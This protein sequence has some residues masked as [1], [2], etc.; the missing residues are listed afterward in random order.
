MITAQEIAAAMEERRAIL[1]LKARMWD[2]MKI[3]MQED[4]NGRIAMGGRD[5]EKWF[6]QQI[7]EYEKEM[8][9]ICK[10]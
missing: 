5:Q 6:K 4:Q 2:M 1:T 7:T 8:H 3:F 9:V 10:D